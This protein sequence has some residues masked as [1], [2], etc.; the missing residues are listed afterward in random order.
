MM[1]ITHSSVNKQTKYALHLRMHLSQMPPAALPA[2]AMACRQ[3]R[4]HRCQSAGSNAPP[5]AV[6]ACACRERHRRQGRLGL[7]GEMDAATQ[8]TG[9]ASKNQT[10]SPPNPMLMPSA[11]TFAMPM[12]ISCG[13][14]RVHITIVSQQ[15][16]T[17]SNV[18][19]WVEVR[20]GE[21][22]RRHSHFE[23]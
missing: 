14:V 11:S 8:A 9:A 21:C 1:I 15:P 23:Y 13:C 3:C 20:R 4:R 16:Q 17:D 22:K 6:N 18:A 10:F 5:P 19:A 2:A 7:G 12:A